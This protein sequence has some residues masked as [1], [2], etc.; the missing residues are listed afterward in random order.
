MKTRRGGTEKAR[1]IVSWS[2]ITILVSLFLLA[3]NGCSVYM[4]AKQPTRKNLEVFSPGTPRSLVLAEIGQPQASETK[5]GKRVDV[6]SF[7]Q[8]YSKGAKAG[9]AF[10]HGAADVFTLGLWEVVGTPTEAI[11]DGQKVAYEV[12][13]DASDKVEKVVTLVG[14]KP[15]SPAQ[16]VRETKAELT[17][18]VKT[19]AI[20]A[21]VTEATNQGAKTEE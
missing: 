3:F 18:D 12:T 10:F 14:E 2:V 11:F 13:Y 16:P 1:G 17:K 19:E 5:A 4:A 6:F 21:P 9:R 8:G 20:P 15:E 7:I